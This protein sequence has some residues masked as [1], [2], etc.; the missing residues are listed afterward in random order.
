DEGRTCPF[1]TPQ[2]C[3]VYPDR[4]GAC[5]I[6]PIGRGSTKT[7]GQPQ[8]RELFFYIR[9][10]HCL[11]FQ[12][13]KPWTAESWMA[14]QGLVPYNF[15]NDLWME[16]ITHKGSLGAEETVERKLLM[17]FMASYN[18]DQFRQ[19]IF[20]TR[21]LERFDLPGPVLDQ[22]REEDE[23]LL[24]LALRWLRFAF[25]GEPTLKLKEGVA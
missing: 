19:F 17:F 16:I 24:R 1:V 20:R 3:R 22:I 6:Y 10:E 13:A 4:P 2:C 15:F 21:F 5:R 25:W 8:T 9:E 23:A 7:K 12:E 11:G 14:D 18:L